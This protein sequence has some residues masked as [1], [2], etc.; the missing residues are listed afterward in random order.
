MLFD[1]E[2]AAVVLVGRMAGAPPSAPVWAVPVQAGQIC[3]VTPGPGTC[4][5]TLSI[6]DQQ[7]AD[8]LY[9]T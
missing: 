1:S 3:H 8:R 7:G 6:S 4:W 9:I 2:S 5:A